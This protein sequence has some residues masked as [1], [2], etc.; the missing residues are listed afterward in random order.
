M[1]QEYI[2]T[3]VANCGGMSR[4]TTTGSVLEDSLIPALERIG[5]RFTK[6][7][8]VGEKVN[9]RK[10]RVDL[11]VEDSDGQFLVEMKWQQTSGTAEQK[12]PFEVINL[13]HSCQESGFR[14][15]YLVLGGTDQGIGSNKSGWTLRQWY[16]DRGLAEYINYEAFV[17]ITTPES[18]IARANSGQL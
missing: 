3:L 9:G 14:K 4:D 18:F 13:M 2:R 1:Y 15:A 6:Q 7:A 8:V 17:E 11:L 5:Y 12:I 10:H 16:L